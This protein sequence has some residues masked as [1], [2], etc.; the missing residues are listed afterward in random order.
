MSFCVEIFFGLEATETK[1]GYYALFYSVVDDFV[2]RRS[3]LRDEHLRLVREAH[4]RGDLILAGALA[5]PVDEALLVF[6]TEDRVTV[7]EF[8]RRDPYVTNGLVTQWEVRPWNV[9]VGDL[10]AEASSRHGGAIARVWS[11]QTKPGQGK[12]YAEHVTNHVLPA[13]RKLGGY[14]GATLLER[15]ASGAIEIIVIT[16]WRSLDAIRK[17]AGADV[18]RA[19]VADEAAA[20]FTQF[21]RRVKHYETIIRDDPRN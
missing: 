5:E 14:A 20:S 4:E 8:A 21:D 16:W 13:L 11:A 1:M 12:S 9:L 10:E 19:V 18:E 15:P 2:A 6:R 7:E 17:F 3:V